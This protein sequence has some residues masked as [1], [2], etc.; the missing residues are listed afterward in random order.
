VQGELNENSVERLLLW[1]LSG[2]RRGGAEAILASLPIPQSALIL[3]A[4][5]FAHRNVFRHC[6]DDLA[7]DPGPNTPQLFS[8]HHRELPHLS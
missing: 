7:G 2:I 1:A 5:K 6:L 8:I 3:A 4:V